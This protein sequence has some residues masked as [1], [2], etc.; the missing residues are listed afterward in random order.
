MEGTEKGGRGEEGGDREG[1]GRGERRGGRE[2]EGIPGICDEY[3]RMK[4]D[5]LEYMG[6]MGEWREFEHILI[7]GKYVEVVEE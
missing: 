4:G 5:D 6:S 7:N 1:E 3:I 2:G